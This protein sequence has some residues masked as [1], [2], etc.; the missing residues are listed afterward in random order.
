MLILSHLGGSDKDIVPQLFFSKCFHV[1]AIFRFRNTALGLL[2]SLF[3]DGETEAESLHVCQMKDILPC[4]QWKYPHQ[5]SL[6]RSM[7]M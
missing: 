7:C 6:L 5:A 2:I 3:K 1:I 4:E